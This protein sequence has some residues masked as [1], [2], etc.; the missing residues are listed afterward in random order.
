MSL[1]LHSPSTRAEGRVRTI[2]AIRRGGKTTKAIE[3]AN[4]KRAY[5]L[6]RK[7]ITFTEDPS[8]VIKRFF[9]RGDL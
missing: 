4:E 3:L 7:G 5:L 6:V 1:K 9:N 8:D 2:R